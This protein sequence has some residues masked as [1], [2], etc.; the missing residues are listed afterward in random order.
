VPEGERGLDDIPNLASASVDGDLSAVL[1]RLDD[2]GLRPFAL[3]LTRPDVG[4]DVVFCFVP[5]LL[6]NSH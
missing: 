2:L 1:A 4:V 5:G 6:E 3:D